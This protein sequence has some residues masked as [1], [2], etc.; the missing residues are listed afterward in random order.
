MKNPICSVCGKPLEDA[1]EME[2]YSIIFCDDCNDNSYIEE[3]VVLID[4]CYNYY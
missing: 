1:R 2:D 4:S 3:D